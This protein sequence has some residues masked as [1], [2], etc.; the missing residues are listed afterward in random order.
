MMTYS[1]H[2]AADHDPFDA[3]QC[4][5]AIRR[6]EEQYGI[7][8]QLLHSIA[9]VESGRWDQSAK[10]IYPWP[11]TVNVEGKPYFFDTKRNAV[12]FVSL[13][14]QKGKRNIDVGCNQISLY[15]HGE[16]FLNIDQA[17][18]PIANSKYAAKFLKT[19]FSNTKDWQSAVGRYH[20]FT[21]HLAKIYTSKVFSRWHSLLNKV[22]PA[23]TIEIGGR[24]T[25]LHKKRERYKDNIIVFSNYVPNQTEVL[26]T[27]ERQVAEISKRIIGQY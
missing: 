15:H 6:Y 25:V 16:N 1:I 12:N 20:S 11:W 21:P 8:G 27:E 17:F 2:A 18:N 9:I 22:M 24:K 19:H 3:Q 10:R 4:V 5:S 13:Q 7:P 26:Q 14:L 23:G